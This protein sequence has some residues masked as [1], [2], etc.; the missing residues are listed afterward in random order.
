MEVVS[1]AVFGRLTAAP[2][3]GHRSFSSTARATTAASGGRSS[4]TWRTISPCSPGMSR[5]RVAGQPAGRIRDL[6]LRGLSRGGARGAGARSGASRWAAPGVGWWPSSS[7]ATVRSSIETLILADTYAGWRGSLPRTRSPPAS[8]ALENARR[9]AGGVRSDVRGHVRAGSAAGARP[10]LER[11]CGRR[12]PE[13][14]AVQLEVMAGLD[15]R[16]LL[17]RV[18]VPTLL[19]WGEFDNARRSASRA[20]SRRRSR[21]RRSSFLR[22]QAT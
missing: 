19:I 12:A 15:Q 4:K 18:R 2:E 11:R 3:V 20:S 6:R 1:A 17:P 14:L 7:I 22:V 8:R 10:A 13:T 9:A 5:V 16:D 21:M